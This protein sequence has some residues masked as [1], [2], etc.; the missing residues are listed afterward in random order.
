MEDAH[1]LYQRL[2]LVVMSGTMT[3]EQNKKQEWKKKFA[4][5]YQWE[6]LEKHNYSK[7]KNGYAILTGKKNNLIAIDID[8]PETDANREL[9]D[10]MMDCNFVQKTK[11]GFHYVYLYDE[12]IA[13][14]TNEKLG[15]D[16]RTDNGCIF[17]EPTECYNEHQELVAH[18]TWIK[19]PE[20]DEGLVAI[21]ND[22]VEFLAKLDRRYV[23]TTAPVV[24]DAPQESESVETTAT[25]PTNNMGI[26]I[27]IVNVLPVEC[28]TNY[29]DWIKIGMIFYNEG[30]TC[31]D[32][33]NISKRATN[34]E[35]GSCEKHWTT[36]GNQIKRKVSCASLW[37]M[38][39]E[40]NPQMFYELMEQRE[41]FWT[42]ILQLNH[43]D[44]AK[45]FYN[46]NPD[47]YLWNEVMGWFS[48]TTK[49]TWK[50]YENKTPSGLCTKV[51]ETMQDL[52]KETKRAELSK[53]ARESSTITDGDK[54]KEMTKKHLAR[55]NAIQLAYKQFG[56]RE[57]TNGVVSFLH[58]YYENEYLEKKM[59]MNRSLFVF[60][61]GVLE[62][63][64]GVFR[65]IVPSDYVSFTCGYDFPTKTRPDVRKRIWTFFLSMFDGNEEVAKYVMY[66]LA[67]CL[68]GV[69]RW[70]EFYFF[71]GN[72]GNG[73]GVL[74]DLLKFVFGD[75]YIS[76]DVS[77][78]TKPMERK[79]QP[80][81]ALVDA[82]WKRIM[83]T[84]EPEA[85]DTLQA[86]LIKRISGGDNIE[87]RTLNSKHIHSYV[88]QFKLVGQA[89]GVPKMNKVDGGVTR[90]M[91]IIQFPLDFKT[92]SDMAKPERKDNWRLA[93][94]DVKH[95]HSKTAI[96]RDEFMLM[97]IETYNESKDWKSLPL[98]R[99]VELETTGYLDEN[100]PLKDWMDGFYEKGDGE[101]ITAEELKN[102]YHTDTQ[103]A[104]SVFNHER[105][106]NFMKLLGFEPR[107]N[108]MHRS[109]YSG[110][111]RKTEI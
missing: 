80:I 10:L 40:T 67:S 73:K 50:G 91:R 107:K 11:K 74:A 46:L 98:P 105:F 16:T 90:R 17:A 62:L 33:D 48:I 94:P 85:S 59:N 84:S 70:E 34:Y 77:L 35:A 81:P 2:G 95:I 55:M 89:N 15:L 36:F 6:K 43:L 65:P 61:D 47:T 7:T 25:D 86:G 24:E 30:L 14:T 8:N 3:A 41:D 68:S 49:N 58:S 76:V 20:E 28:L 83:M 88:P 100:N 56:S 37:K 96:W 18:Y 102:Q 72:G 111:I 32:W 12:R 27:K 93:D 53:Y 75:Y 26:L 1:A 79:D 45:Y 103:T 19:R 69:N 99:A 63:D 97:L 57:F 66:V 82:K 23:R 5:Q 13:Q 106:K 22:V 110:L 21:P 109:V 39:K 44:V 60:D 71:T 104:T 51:A 31:A 9:M 87:A 101:P 64:T 42:L 52:T 78:F 29:A 54:Q 108:R 92:E 4:F 38:L